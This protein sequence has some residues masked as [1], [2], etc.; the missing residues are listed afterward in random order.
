LT[1]AAY[2][3]AVYWSRQTHVPLP[4]PRGAVVHLQ[5]FLKLGPP[6]SVAYIAVAQLVHK[7]ADTQEA[8]ERSPYVIYEEDKPLGPAHSAEKDIVT[9]GHGR[10]LHKGDVFILSASDNSDP[11]TN[12]RNYWVVLLPK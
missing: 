11:R 4:E 12:G 1:L 5:S 7:L 9:T 10:F 6:D 2:F 3:P 8:P